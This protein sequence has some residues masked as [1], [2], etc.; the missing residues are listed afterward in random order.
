LTAVILILA[1]ASDAGAA[2]VARWLAGGIGPEAVRIVRPE[3]FS[4]A[5]WSQRIDMYGRAITRASWPSQ[6]PIEDSQVGAVL[7]RIRY[8]PVP[9]FRGAS[10]KDRD[11]ATAEFQAVVSSWLGQFGERAVH[12]VRRHTLLT[13]VLPLL[14]WASAAAACD[15]PVAERTIASSARAL[16]WRS[17][18]HSQ[19][20]QPALGAVDGTVLVAGNQIGGTLVAR[21]GQHCLATAR[22]LGSPLL[23][24]RFVTNRSETVLV[25]VDPLPSLTEPWAAVLTGQML[26]SMAA[27]ARS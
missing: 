7:N 9:K 5:R 14:H 22:A 18:R 16:R 4:L 6:E 12:V 23:E 25:D 20:A 1:H 8:L 27:G 21:Y 26:A 11:Y 19:D 3:T 17:G 10:A 13:P 2:L 15:L 24:F